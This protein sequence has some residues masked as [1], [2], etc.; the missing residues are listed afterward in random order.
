MNKKVELRDHVAGA[1]YGF[2]IGDSVGATTEFMTGFGA[3]TN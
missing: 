1:I 3:V 2:V